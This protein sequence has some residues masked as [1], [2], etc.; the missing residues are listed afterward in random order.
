MLSM[1]IS[2]ISFA[3][4]IFHFVPEV[5]ARNIDGVCSFQMQNMTSAPLSGKILISIKE[6]LKPQ[7]VVDIETP[8]TIISKGTSALSKSIV[9]N[10]IFKFA[11]NAYGQLVNQ[12]KNFPPGE[13][14]FCFTFIPAE[15]GDPEYEN[16]FDATIEPLIPI[17]LL[18]PSN[19]DTICLKRPVLSWQPPMPYNGAMTFRLMLTEKKM[20]KNGVEA[21]L[22]NAPLLLLDNISSTTITYPSNYPEL[23]EGIT[24][25]WQVVAYQQKI[26]VSTSEVWAFT[27]KCKDDPIVDNDS[28]RELKF[29]VNGNY[30][31]TSQYLKF[32]FLNNYNIKKLQYT[33]IDVEEGGKPV[34]YVPEVKLTQGLNKVDI[35]ITEIGLKQ[36]KSYLLKVFPFNESP[37]E[38]RFIYQ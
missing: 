11:N 8:V 36:G 31:I 27:L 15:K 12:T 22:K 25:Y 35:D 26:I 5:Y 18:I 16:C 10:S 29:M 14:S 24:Y 20:A 34:K 33:I 19:E 17:Q 4:L 30:Y 3:Q 1:L 32:S 28:Y 6:N 9:G 23:K 37:V 38:I 2:K 21:M 7:P 13:Y